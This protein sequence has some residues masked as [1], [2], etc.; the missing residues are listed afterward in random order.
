MHI[1]FDSLRGIGLSQAILSRLGAAGIP[2]GQCLARVTETQRDRLT[3]HD[4]HEDHLARPTH[5]LHLTLQ[6]R[7]MPPTVGDWVLAGPDDDG[8][9]WVHHVLEAE[10]QVARRA[11]DGRR[12]LLASNVD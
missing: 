2:P 5:R 8:E 6:A 12:Q 3:L 11:N 1:D 9:W 10:T 4:G 7:D